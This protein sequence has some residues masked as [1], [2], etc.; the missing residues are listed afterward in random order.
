MS[1]AA[2]TDNFTPCDLVLLARTAYMNQVRSIISAKSFK[3]VDDKYVA[4][5]DD[6]GEI[7]SYLN[8]RAEDI[9][10]GKIGKQEVLKS[11]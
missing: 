7:K 10:I 2:L 9:F 3:K 1:I 4:C 11:L 6:S 5:A 8:I